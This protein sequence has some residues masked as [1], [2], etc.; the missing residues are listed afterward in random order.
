LKVGIGDANRAIVTP[1]DYFSSEIRPMRVHSYFEDPKS[2]A[3]W[4][5]AQFHRFDLTR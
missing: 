1:Q 5:L 4:F 2:R 3:E